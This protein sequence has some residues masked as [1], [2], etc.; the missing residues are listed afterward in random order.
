MIHLRNEPQVIE[1]RAFSSARFAFKRRPVQY[2]AFISRW[3]SQVELD[4]S[5]PSGGANRLHTTR[6]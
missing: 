2:P 1:K 3:G 6:L 4:Q 5:S